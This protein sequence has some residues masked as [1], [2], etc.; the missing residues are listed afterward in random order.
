MNGGTDYVEIQLAIDKA[1]DGDTVLVKPGQ[2]V[3][4]EPVTFKGK[5][6]L[7]KSEGGADETTIRMSAAPADPDRASVVIFEN[8]ESE[9]SVLEGFTLTGGTGTLFTLLDGGLIGGGGVLFTPPC[10]PRIIGCVMVENRAPIGGGG[11]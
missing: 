11:S 6:I 4:T 5:A 2:Y 1:A 3:I 8:G 10:A 9:Q 7:V